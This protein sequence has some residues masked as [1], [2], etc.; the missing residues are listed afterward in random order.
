MIS[1]T[2][3]AGTGDAG[4]AFSPV[5]TVTDGTAVDSES[6]SWNINSPITLVPIDTLQNN[7]G[8]VVSFHVKATD[9]TSGATL[10]FSATGLPNGLSLSSSGLV[11]GTIVAGTG[12][13]GGAFSPTVTVT[14]GTAVD[15]ETF[16]WNV[17]S[18]ITLLPIDT[19][20]NNEG[21]VVSFHVK[22][23]DSTSGATLTFSAT[24]LPNNLSL[25][26]SSGLISGT[27][28]AGTA[29]AGGAFWPTVT[30]TDG[31]AVASEAFS[32]N[33]N[34]PI[35]LASI[36]DQQ[37]SEGAV[38]SLSVLAS[39][40]TSGATLTYRESGLPEGLTLNASSGLI[41]GTIV[42]GAADAGAASPEI[43]VTDGTAVAS[44]GFTWNLGSAITIDGINTQRSNEGSSVS[45][46]L[47][48][49]DANSLSLTFS[50]EGL[51]PGLSISANGLISGTIASGA[52][53]SGTPYYPVITVTDGTAVA[54]TE[55]TWNLASPS[56]ISGLFTQ[57]SSEGSTVSLSVIASDSNSLSLT[58]SALGLPANLSINSSTGLIS[59]TI[60]AAAANVGPAAPIITVTDGTAVAS[61]SFTWDLTSAISLAPIAT[62]T[63]A[64][65]ASVSLSL[66]ASDANSISLTWGESGLPSGLT[67]NP[68]S[69]LVY[70]TI[71]A[72]A[73]NAG[74]A[75]PEITVSDG[76]DLVSEGFTW[77]LTSAISLASIAT[78][79]NA[80]GNSVSL[81]VSA[82]DANSLA[83]TYSESGLPTGLTLNPTS[84]LIHGTILAES[85]YAPG[86]KRC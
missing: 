27:I 19:L 66:S 8:D 85:E 33:I 23:A 83:L 74:P 63:N 50:A 20:Q 86:K 13:A 26:S 68:T 6:F 10:T 39:D 82:T 78:Q 46:S 54:T 14:D 38:V 28:A 79:T 84:G 76:T 35:T 52:A 24:G 71:G 21:D 65:G 11:S 75:F 72:G 57:Q 40:S 73:A 3:A 80:E 1:G 16:S 34:S 42:A 53:N 69:G 25:N 60:G 5:I 56:T 31:T 51:P 47:T 32:W 45:L 77:D 49:S 41:A 43:T 48:A 81:Q 30:V 44:E 64:E 55:F 17:N 58:Y 18:P 70:G 4:G 37:S 36:A 9:S 12:D 7:E 59:G 2:I 15:S 29:D 62:Q 61:E 67:L 22:A